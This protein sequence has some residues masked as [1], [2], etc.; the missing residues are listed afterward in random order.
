MWSDSPGDGQVGGVLAVGS[1]T[2]LQRAKV[3]KTHAVGVSIRGCARL[4]GIAY[5]TARRYVKEADTLGI[6]EAVT[7]PSQRL[8]SVELKRKVSRG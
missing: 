4:A 8:W 1:V 7:Q 3:M 5:E 6:D 2:H